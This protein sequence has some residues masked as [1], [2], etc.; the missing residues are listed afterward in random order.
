MDIKK[1]NFDFSP[2]QATI[3]DLHVGKKLRERR[4]DK[5]MSQEK[6]GELIGISFKQI[7]KYEHGENRISS[8][9]LFAISKALNVEIESFFIGLDRFPVDDD[10]AKSDIDAK[11][12]ED[13]INKYYNMKEPFPRAEFLRLIRAIADSDEDY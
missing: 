10:Y 8:S 7:R 12:I 5:K 4:K 6:L 3:V 1:D 13:L 11:E 2:R 9:S